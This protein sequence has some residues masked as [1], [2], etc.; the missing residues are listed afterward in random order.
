MVNVVKPEVKLLAKSWTDLDFPDYA[1]GE[2]GYGQLAGMELSSFST[3]A[4]DLVEFAGRSCYQSFNKPN[5]ATAEN[6]DYIANIITQGHES[7]LEHAT[8]SFYLTGVSRAL[9]HELIRHRHLSYS[10]M[11]QRF[12]DES[13][14]NI[15]MPPAISALFHEGSKEYETVVKSARKA[16]KKYTALVESLQNEGLPRKLAREAARAVLPN[17]LETRIVVSGNLRAWRDYLK[18]RTSPN[19]DAEIRIVSQMIL[20]ELYDI[21]PSVFK[22]FVE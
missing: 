18:K 14:A 19:A 22:D 4:E 16:L 11:S 12:V 2:D 17:C 6:A 8:V 3:D 13:E 7:V 20:S 9:T 21:A 1:E 5:P 15:V 10:Q